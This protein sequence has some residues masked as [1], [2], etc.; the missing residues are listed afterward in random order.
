MEPYSKKLWQEFSF[1]FVSKE[2][3]HKALTTVEASVEA[4]DFAACLAPFMFLN[5]SRFSCVA[6]P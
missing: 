4:K 2:A 3:R 1:S 5:F 6:F